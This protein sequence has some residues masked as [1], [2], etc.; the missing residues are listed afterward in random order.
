VISTSSSDEKLELARK[1]GATHTINYRKTP[2]W[3][4]KVLELTGGV[5]VDIV[6]EVV[7]GA[8][9]IDS[10]NSV[11]YDG[12][13]GLVGILDRED[14]AVAITRPLLFGGKT[15]KWSVPDVTAF[16][17]DVLVSVKAALGAGSR[18]MGVEL[19]EFID[20]H[21]IHPPIAKVFKFEEAVEAIDALR[22]FSGVGKIVI[23][24]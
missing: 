18:Q 2:D 10:I 14:G 7:G 15:S 24:V 20:K 4:S 8:G 23:E 17:A 19:S 5:G 9:L 22:N 6:V 11:R 1:F 21:Q 16:D 12:R 3:S 13:V